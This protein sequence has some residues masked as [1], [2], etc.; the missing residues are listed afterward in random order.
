[1]SV[2]RTPAKQ[3]ALELATLLRTEHPDYTYLKT[4]FSYLRAELG[5]SVPT[6][7]KQV[8]NVPTESEIRRFYE[9]VW[10]T[11][12]VQ[13]MVMIKTLFYT[14]VRVSEL[15]NIQ[16]EHVD[17]ENCQI[18]ISSEKE[19]KE[20][21]VMF[22]I[23]FK[24][25]LATHADLMRKQQATYLFESSWK[26]PYSERGI[27]KILKRYALLAGL[28]HSVP[29]NQLRHFLLMWLKKEGID[30]A[31][32]QPYSGNFNRLLEREYALR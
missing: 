17:L 6:A 20:R 25:T 26:R 7:T 19:G 8:T 18:C 16:I 9:A 15:I 29:P 11:Q 4:V 28:S 13:D 24:E 2:E 1:M 14:G 32:I 22:P 3:K 12:N 30:D 21:I 23:P 31:L 27:R 10:N 5:I